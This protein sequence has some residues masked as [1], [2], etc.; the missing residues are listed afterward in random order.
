MPRIRDCLPCLV[1]CLALGMGWPAWAVV[2]P[3]LYD[4]RVPVADQS[5]AALKQGARE[6][7]LRV[8]T[9][10]TGQ[11]SFEAWPGVQPFLLQA[12]RLVG[13]FSYEVPAAPAAGFV[14]RLRFAPATL[15]RI[16][17]ESGLPLWPVNR[18]PVLLWWA[19]QEGDALRRLDAQRDA[20]WLLAMQDA[21]QDRG[22]P[23]QWPANDTED[24]VALESAQAWALDEAAIRQ[25]SARYG[26][27]WVLA[28][29]F[30]PTPDGRW[31]GRWVLLGEGLPQQLEV[32]ADTPALA[33]A[34]LLAL[35]T[36]TLAARYRIT[37]TAQPVGG[38]SLELQGVQS[39][40]DYMASRALLASLASVASVVPEQVDGD[41]VRYR[42]VLLGDVAAFADE[43]ALHKEVEALPLP[44]TDP[45]AAADGLLYRWRT[46]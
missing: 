36:D 16:V 24:R 29:G 7:L 1:F 37:I 32:Q 42:L 28:G 41:R 10:L 4:A 8:L 43:L 13:Q 18:P 31:Q 15:E 23:L 19:W 3:G 12:D 14:L 9:R 34:T 6:G 17:R 25:A 27:T 26:N 20:D 30:A 22:V 21:A 38:V 2:P 44:V 40:A 5:P 35:V 45:Q 11:T 33:V 39:F 46:P